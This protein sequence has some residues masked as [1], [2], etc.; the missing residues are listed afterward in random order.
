MMVGQSLKYGGSFAPPGQAAVEAMPG[1]AAVEA[2]PRQAAVEACVGGGGL[3]QGTAGSKL[4]QGTAGS[5]GRG[6]SGQQGQPCPRLFAEAIADTADGLDAFA[7]FAEFFSQPDDLDI[8][9]AL[10]DR[11]VVAA[12]GIDDLVA[13]VDSSRMKGEVV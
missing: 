7:G 10:G 4:R 11:I 9:R 13:G 3:R 12:D 8:D 6:Q 2:M 5:M 1:Q